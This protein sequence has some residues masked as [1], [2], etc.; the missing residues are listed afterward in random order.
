MITLDNRRIRLAEAIFDVVVELPPER[1]PTVLAERCGSDMELRSFVE[2]L[3]QSDEHA[4]LSSSD[5]RVFRPSAAIPLPDRIGSYR[6]VRSLGEGG[7]GVV[8]EAEQE[9]PRRSVALKMLRPGILSPRAVQRFEHEADLLGQLQHPGIAQVFE[10]G[11]TEVAGAGGAVARHPFFAM[12]LV[13]GRTLIEYARENKLSIAEQLALVARVCDAVQHAHQK[14][15]IHRDL[16]PANILVNDEGQPK[17]LDFGVARAIGA[18]LDAPSSQTIAGQLL[19]TIPYMSP[20]QLEGNCHAID[21]RSDVYSLGVVAFELLTGQLPF[22]VADVP[23]VQAIRILSQRDP[24]PA[25]AVRPELRGD[26]EAIIGKALERNADRRYASCAEL[27]ADIRRY[28]RNETVLAR[29]PTALHQLAKFA[30]RNRGLVVGAAVAIT[31]LM[32]GTIGTATFAWRESREAERA[33]A[34]AARAES[35]TRFLREMLASA[36]PQAMGGPDVTVR[37]VLD[38]AAARINAGELNRDP[39]I[40][41]ALHNTIGE[42]YLNLGNYPE[43]R[44][45]LQAAVAL[46]GEQRGSLDADV[47]LN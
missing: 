37:Q 11:T 5:H 27:A 12:E 2:Q 29:P 39:E 6:I 32:A 13:R 23:S 43:A 8:Y 41:A 42:S 10:A 33:E 31:A 1:R 20:E 26:V 14:G 35:V 46:F 18:D 4:S 36:D 30:R 25:G 34:H 44:R 3:I 24:L 40:T 9:H 15:V 22:D 19:G 38:E 21:T 7:M 45:H 28:L 47:I 17:I 16:K